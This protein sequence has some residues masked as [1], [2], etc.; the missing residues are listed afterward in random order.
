[1]D[2]ISFDKIETTGKTYRTDNY[3]LFKRLE[4]NRPVV[5]KRVS[6]IAHS[7]ATN[8]YI[9][10]PIVVNENFE[11]VDGQGRLEALQL[12]GLPVD[13]VIAKGA[14]LK[15]CVALNAYTTAW[16]VNDYI[17]SFCEMGNENY[18]RFKMLLSE[19]SPPLAMNVIAQF[20]TGYVQVPTQRIKLGEL[21][22]SADVIE[23][24]RSYLNFALKVQ[25]TISKTKGEVRYYYYAVGFALKSGADA[26]R[27]ISVISGAKLEPAPDL[28]TALD[29]L[30]DLYNWH[31]RDGSKKLYFFPMYEESMCKKLGWYKARWADKRRQMRFSEV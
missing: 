22:V 13:F 6:R 16:T 23:E 5:A 30:S 4:G 28:R 26:D 7:I 17:D 10:N 2:F 3:D 14:T 19:F 18:I 25:P 12:S 31:L 8:G 11:V 9:Y 20:S 21:V 1:M 29:N 24:A 15:D 27:L